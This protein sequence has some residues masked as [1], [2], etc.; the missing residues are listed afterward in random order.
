M[1]MSEGLMKSS[2]ISVLAQVI[3]WSKWRI[4]YDCVYYIIMPASVTFQVI[5]DQLL[6]D[7]PWSALLAGFYCSIMVHDSDQFFGCAMSND[8]KALDYFISSQSC[9]YKP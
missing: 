5:I 2:L 9:L 3:T 1:K 7:L 6:S 4:G 8:I